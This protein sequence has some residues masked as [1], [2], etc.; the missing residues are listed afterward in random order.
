[1]KI[2]FIGDSDIHRWPKCLLPTI[3]N[4]TPSF[5]G[6]DGA[7]LAEIV[8]LV[9]E[10]IASATHTDDDLILVV[11]AGENDTS[12]QDSQRAFQRLLDL[13]VDTTTLIFLGPKIEPWHFND[14]TSRRQYIRLSRAF[15]RLALE[16]A[17]S[18]QIYFIDCLLMFC[19]ESA[20]LPG[21]L[22][23]NRAVAEG[24]YFDTDQLHLSDDGYRI[25]KRTV[26]ECIG[27]IMR[28]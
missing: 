10:T 28:S 15:E 24:Q 9:E 25:W 16:H 27:K 26:E 21:A 4:M 5:F 23:G 20:S 6:C 3:P 2:T 13:L 19:G 18:A 11:C 14:E 22:F 12:L 1:M 7:T 17:R 8:P